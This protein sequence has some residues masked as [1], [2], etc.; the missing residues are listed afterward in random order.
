MTDLEVRTKRF[1]S[2]T[3]PVGDCICWT[4][5]TDDYGVGVVSSFGK[6][7]RYAWMLEHGDIPDGMIISNTCNNAACVKLEHLQCKWRGN[8]SA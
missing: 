4:G 6:A 8:N 2:K 5:A 7:P 1:W 3:V